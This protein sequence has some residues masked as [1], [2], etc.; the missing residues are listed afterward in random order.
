MRDHCASTDHGAVADGVPRQYGR[1]SPDPNIIA[2]ADRPGDRPHLPAILHREVVA[3][4]RYADLGADK[5]VVPDP[6]LRGIQENAVVVDHHTP[7]EMDVLADVTS[8]GRPDVCLGIEVTA[9]ELLQKGSADHRVVLPVDATAEGIGTRH[10]P[11][12]LVN[13]LILGAGRY[14]RTAPVQE[15]HAEPYACTLFILIIRYS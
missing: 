5:G 4:R 12:E 2:D 11:D 13:V 3:R 10:R 9:E 7:A 14:A 6:D 1:G 15:S 8:E